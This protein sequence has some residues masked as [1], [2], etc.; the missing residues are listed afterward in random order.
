MKM[1]MT[2]GQKECYTN[3]ELQLPI[4]TDVGLIEVFYNIET[5]IWRVEDEEQVANIETALQIDKGIEQYF[6]CLARFH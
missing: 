5:G 2:M 3:M 6:N 1:M 4:K